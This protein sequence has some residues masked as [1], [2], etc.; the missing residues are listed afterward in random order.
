MPGASSVKPPAASKTH[1][2]GVPGSN[3]G[4]FCINNSIFKTMLRISATL[5]KMIT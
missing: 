3:P 1:N 5:R 4:Y 2:P